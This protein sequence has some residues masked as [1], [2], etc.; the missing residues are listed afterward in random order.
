M[1]ASVGGRAFRGGLSAVTDVVDAD[2]VRVSDLTLD[3]P[4]AILAER[5]QG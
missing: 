3:V 4:S 1:T 2:R 5:E